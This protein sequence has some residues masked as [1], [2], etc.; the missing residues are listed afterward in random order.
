MKIA[1]F[2]T[3]AVGGYFGGRLAEAGEDVVFLARGETLRALQNDG[4]RVTSILGNFRISPAR[5]TGDPAAVGPVDVVLVGVKAWQ[6]AAAALLMRPLVGPS[7]VVVPLQNG[8]EA[9]EHLGAALGRERILGGLCRIL[10]WLEGPG[11]VC[12]AGIDPVIAFGEWDGSETDRVVRLRGVFGRAKGVRA[13]VSRDIRAAL[14]GKLMFITSVSGLGAVTRTP[15]GTFRSV[16]ESRSL[17]DA[18]IREVWAVGRAH[19][20]NLGDDAPAK[21]LA[22]VDALPE[23]AT[24]SLHRDILEG[25]PSELEAQ[26]GAVVRFAREVGVPA[27]HTAFLYAS[28]LP[29]ERKARGESIR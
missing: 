20:A 14:W 27:P 28:L 18:V 15:A 3:G 8:V 25:R 11:H 22:A 16:P 24:S 4:L 21:V 23:G 6:V 2:G 29:Q 13:E 12:H 10:C 17:L 9:S 5:A 7:T 1:V 19:G 26:L